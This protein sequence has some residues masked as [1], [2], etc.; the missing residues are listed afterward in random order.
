MV[1]SDDFSISAM[2]GIYIMWARSSSMRCYLSKAGNSN[3]MRKDLAMDYWHVRELVET[4]GDRQI[5]AEYGYNK[6]Y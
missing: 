1:S 3:D 4:S 5:D 2:A 6:R